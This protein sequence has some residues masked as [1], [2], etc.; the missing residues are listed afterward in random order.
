[1]SVHDDLFRDCLNGSSHDVPRGRDVHRR[2]ARVSK[3]V[4]RR[5]HRGSTEASG[6]LEAGAEVVAG[7]GTTRRS[8]G[9]DSSRQRIVRPGHWI[10][11]GANGAESTTIC[12]AFSSRK[13]PASN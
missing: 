4:Y 1:M 11:A 2:D 13:E 12:W 3:D 7:R 10:D 5:G 8:G 9:L 6:E